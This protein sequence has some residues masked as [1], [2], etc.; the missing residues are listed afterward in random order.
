VDHAYSSMKSSR[1]AWV[2]QSTLLYTVPSMKILQQT[3]ETNDK[4]MHNVFILL[5][6]CVISFSFYF[7][8]KVI[9]NHINS[10]ILNFPYIYIYIYIYIER[11]RERERERGDTTL[12][13]LLS[14]MKKDF[15]S[16]HLTRISTRVI[17]G[18]NYVKGTQGKLG[19]QAGVGIER[20]LE[21]SHKFVMTLKS[22]LRTKMT[23]TASFL[24]PLR[25]HLQ[26]CTLC[27][28][29]NRFSYLI[30]KSLN[31]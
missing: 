29:P 5:Y 28:S 7:N 20:W 9:F 26:L 16:C 11:E 21:P 15:I 25:T 27:G 3:G 6:I 18:I 22:P 24:S 17:L 10:W 13:F 2:V 23:E 12:E 30:S 4:C 19:C 31:D 14:V 1:C 8:G